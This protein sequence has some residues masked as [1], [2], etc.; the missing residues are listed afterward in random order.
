MEIEHAT[1]GLLRLL[2]IPLNFSGTPAAVRHAPPALGEHTNEI[3]TEFADSTLTKF[4]NCV[5]QALCEAETPKGGSQVAIRGQEPQ[6]G[7]RRPPPRLFR[8][9]RTSAIARHLR[10]G[11]V[12]V[13]VVSVSINST[14]ELFRT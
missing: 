8:N 4:R 6:E 10:L 12:A 3:L 1:A 7:G 9:A 13:R 2:G 14:V 11:S 5:R